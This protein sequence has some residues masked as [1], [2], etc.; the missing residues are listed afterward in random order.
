[1]PY[2]ANAYRL[3]DGDEDRAVTL[4]SSGYYYTRIKENARH[5]A[6]HLL[7]RSPPIRCSARARRA[8]LLHGCS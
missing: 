8:A 2:L 7:R 3:A 6:T 4:F 5:I 1:V